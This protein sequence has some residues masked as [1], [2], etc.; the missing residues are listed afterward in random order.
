MQSNKFFG[1]VSSDFA[2][3]RYV[4][5]MDSK[6]GGNL[7][8]GKNTSAVFCSD[9][10]MLGFSASK[11]KF[12]GKMLQ[13]SNKVLE[14]GCMDGFGSAIV[15]SFVKQLVSIDFYKQHLEQAKT[16]IGPH[17][18]NIDFRGHDILDGAVDGDFDAAYSLDV[19][20]HIDPSQ[21]DL[22]MRNVVDSLN[23]YGTFIVG[24]PSLKSQEY[25]SEANKFAHINC[26]SA[27]QLKEFTS[28]YFRNVYSFGMND[29]VLHTGYSPMCQYLINI[30][31]VP[32]R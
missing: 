8:L 28:Q 3:E 29:E 16:N 31:S 22:Y 14:V 18:T 6:N 4:P 21:E 19:L 23:D 24:I 12:I 7:V 1:K 26:K 2:K 10:K 25:A 32:I 27:E 15:S 5:V 30:C 9:P 13:N 11:H 17:F 20:E